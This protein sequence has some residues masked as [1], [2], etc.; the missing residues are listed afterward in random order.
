[1][2][3]GIDYRTIIVV[4]HPYTLPASRLN[5][6]I[7][8]KYGYC[9][10]NCGRIVYGVYIMCLFENIYRFYIY[11]T[12]FSHTYSCLLFLTLSFQAATCVS[13][14]AIVTVNINSTIICISGTPVSQVEP[15]TFLYGMIDNSLQSLQEKI[16]HLFVESKLCLNIL[17]LNSL[18]ISTV[19]YN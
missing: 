13:G 14:M 10:W 16:N 3:K 19:I 12:Y 9:M 17:L 15:I 11:R 8:K 18:N 6:G 2:Q 4:H 7:L 1:M 5:V